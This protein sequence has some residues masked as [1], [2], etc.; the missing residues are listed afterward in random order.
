[1]KFKYISLIYDDKFFV[2][3]NCDDT[4]NILDTNGNILSDT[5]YKSV[6]YIS[7]GLFIVW[8]GSKKNI[9]NANTKK[10][11]SPDL[12]FDEV[13][14]Y[15]HDGYTIVRI[16]GLGENLI[17]SDGKMCDTWVDRIIENKFAFKNYL[18]VEKGN[19][20]NLIGKDLK[21]L[22]DDFL[23]ESIYVRENFIF[24]MENGPDMDYKWRIRDIKGNLIFED[25]WFDEV[26]IYTNDMFI[27]SNKNKNNLMDLQG[28]LISKDLWFDMIYNPKPDGIAKVLL[29]RKENFLNLATGELCSE[30]WFDEVRYNNGLFQYKTDGKWFIKKVQPKMDC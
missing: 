8:K 5:W 1:M 28:N 13:L 6:I 14:D 10:L 9:F 12:W 20:Q 16:N 25:K 19:K 26:D 23:F 21:L 27:V 30:G 29:N 7:D 15:C 4:C 22:F 2:V 3:T 17:S 11:I 18:V 24:T